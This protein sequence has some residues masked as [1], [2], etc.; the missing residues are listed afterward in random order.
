[1]LMLTS[2]TK[3]LA[4][5]TLGSTIT[6]GACAMDDANSGDDTQQSTDS[7]DTTMDPQGVSPIVPAATL[8]NFIINRWTGGNLGV[9]HVPGG[10]IQLLP[11]GQDTFDFF[12]WTTT[13]AFVIGSGFCADLQR[14]DNL[15]ITWVKQARIGAGTHLIG[16]HTSY[17]VFPV[18]C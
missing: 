12:G 4:V 16:A 1:M 11:P 6:L 3:L 13:A 18:K 2:W 5:L 17:M 8:T 9:I 7:A 15:G 10:P 14:S